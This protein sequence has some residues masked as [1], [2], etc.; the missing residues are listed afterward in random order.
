MNFA[1]RS[2]ALLT[3]LL[4]LSACKAFDKEEPPMCPRVSA[5]ADSV[6]MTKFRPGQGRDMT[7]VELRAEMTSYHGSCRYNAETRQMIIKMQVGI[8]A[9][10]RPALSGRH[11]DIAYY[12]AIPAFYPDPKAKQILPV[13]LDFS[14]DSNRAHVTDGEV[15]I[16][17]PITNLKELPKFEVFVGLQLTPDELAFN[18]QQKGAK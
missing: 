11:A 18:R 17:I 15:E 4:A 16:S 5:L 2:I 14:S 13:S 6:V 7:D 9:E 8:D 3:T 12:I 1:K 10:R